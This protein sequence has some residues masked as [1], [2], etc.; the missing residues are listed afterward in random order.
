LSL[1]VAHGIRTIAFPAI[2][3][4]V[5]GYPKDEA[6]EVASGAIERFLNSEPSLQ[7]VKLVFYSVDDLQVFLDHQTFA[8]GD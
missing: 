6:A 3:T 2:S 8:V 7:L 4:G 1:A 5:Y